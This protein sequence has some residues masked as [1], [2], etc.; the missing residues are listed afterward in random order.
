MQHRY[1]IKCGTSNCIENR[2]IHNWNVYIAPVYVNLLDRGS[3]KVHVCHFLL[4]QSKWWIPCTLVDGKRK[5][6]GYNLRGP[7]PECCSS[8]E[9][10]SERSTV[11][12]RLVIQ[13]CN[14]EFQID[15]SHLAKLSGLLNAI[16]QFIFQ[17][18][19]FWT[20]NLKFTVAMAALQEDNKPTW[21]SHPVLVLLDT[22]D[23]LGRESN[24]IG[25]CISKRFIQP[26]C[27]LQLDSCLEMSSKPT[28]THLT[29]L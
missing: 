22:L 25:L 2:L 29:L 26:L 3:H 24:F 14:I 5:N 13:N 6:C 12:F 20:T 7:I 10:Q 19:I 28:V 18:C 8:K 17:C 11:N 21:V 27:T 16:G 1:V 4:W 9:S 15:Q 23:K